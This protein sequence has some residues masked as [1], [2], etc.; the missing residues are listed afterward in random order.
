[1]SSMF[2]SIKPTSPNH[3]I[4]VHP[5]YHGKKCTLCPSW[6][7]HSVVTWKTNQPI[8]PIE[9]FSTPKPRYCIWQLTSSSPDTFKKCQKIPP[10][11]HKKT[12]DHNFVDLLHLLQTLGLPLLYDQQ[13]IG[14]PVFFLQFYLK[15]VVILIMILLF[16]SRY[17]F[18]NYI[19]PQ[20]HF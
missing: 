1:M 14:L 12:I 8:F 7:P 16:L 13:T 5:L 2:P 19:V 6:H 9:P 10:K 18:N 4:H 15:I 17:N 20:Y 11:E 3:N